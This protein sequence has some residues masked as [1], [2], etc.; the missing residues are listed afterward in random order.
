VEACK[1]EPGLWQLVGDELMRH[2]AHFNFFL[3]RVA[4]EDVV[5]GGKRV[6]VGQVLL[7]SLHAAATDPDLFPAPNVFNA[8]RIQPRCSIVFGAGPHFCPGAAL[9]RQWLQVALERLFRTLSGLRL[10]GSYHDLE[11]QAGSISMPKQILV[12]WNKTYT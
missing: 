10:A 12:T 5:L 9:S 2:K 4:T 1:S 7:P 3:P 8:R 6:P 11:W